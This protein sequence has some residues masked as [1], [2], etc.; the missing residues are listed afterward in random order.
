MDRMPADQALTASELEEA[1]PG[2]PIQVPVRAAYR[3][4]LL[5]VAVATV[6]LVLIY[7]GLI[8]AVAGVLVVHATSNTWILT[9]GSGLLGKLIVYFGPLLIGLVLLFFLTKPLF[10]PRPPPPPSLDLPVEEAPVLH[11]LIERIRRCLGAPRPR[12]V[13]VDCAV[14]ASAGYASGPLAWVTGNLELTIGLP[15]LH[16]MTTRQLAGILA[17]ELGHFAQGSSM[18]LTYLIRSINGWFARVVFERDAWDLRLEAAARG[19]DLRLSIVLHVARFMVWLGRLLLRGLMMMGH[20]IGMFML[21]QMEYDA[22]RYEA[23]LV[24]SDAFA[25]TAIRLR[26]LA[27]AREVALAR[28]AEGW[29]RRRVC[30]DLPGLTTA[31]VERLPAEVKKA[32]EEREKADDKPGV[33]DTHPPD[34]ARIASAEAEAAPGQFRLDRPAAAL[35]AD[36]RALSRRATE[37]YYREVLELQVEVPHLAPLWAFLEEIEDREQAARAVKE[38]FGDF[39]S[40]FHPLLLAPGLPPAPSS[41]AEAAA[42]VQSSSEA[43]ARAQQQT[44]AQ[45]QRLK[46]EVLPLIAPA[47]FGEAETA[48]RTRLAISLGLI[49]LAGD[50]PVTPSDRQTAERLLEVLAALGAQSPRVRALVSA[51]DQAVAD[52]NR[53]LSD[54]ENSG[55]RTDAVRALGAVHDLLHQLE[56][57]LLQVSFPFRHGFDHL[58]VHTYVTNDLPPLEPESLAMI[59]RAQKVVQRLS[60][61]YGQVLGKLARIAL[62]VERARLSQPEV[63]T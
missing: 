42:K 43:L 31:L 16:G 22:D 29:A 1:F 30:D 18:R 8:L 38:V 55:A 3:L 49:Q 27:V 51:C 6:V 34:R 46:P 40:P 61:F 2:T 7:V 20:A 5:L 41:L 54:L 44:L 24:G 17:H 56:T 36:L 39:F 32:V 60:S 58:S 19:A 9:E 23:R 37:H 13:R 53:H 15:L 26:H 35:L 28:L 59:L 50:D 25:G 48:V 45:P 63:T 4:G 12:S 52:I 47:G 57:A 14:N 62:S 21:R 10:A 11:V 33:F